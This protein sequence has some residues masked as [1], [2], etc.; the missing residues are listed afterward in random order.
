MNNNTSD[1]ILILGSRG[2][3][4]SRL[5]AHLQEKGCQV[6][7]LNENE[8][9]FE[10]DIVADYRSLEADDLKPYQVVIWLAGHSSV[11]AATEDPAGAFE[12]NVSG[13]LRLADSLS[14]EQ[15]LI[16]ASSASLYSRNPDLPPSTEI[17]E[18][19]IGEEHQN[20]YD[21]SKFAFDKLLTKRRKN[22][23]GL[24]FGTVCG[25][26]S[27]P[28]N[29]LLLNSMV[30]SAVQTGQVKVSNAQAMRSV[31]AMNDLIEMVYLLV[32]RRPAPGFYDLASYSM[33][34]GDFGKT[35]AAQLRAELIEVPGQG[36][37]SFSVSARKIYSALDYPSPTPINYLID[38]LKAFYS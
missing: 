25:T 38:E 10:N 8:G 26:S 22:F 19:V 14:E 28:R 21:L 3:I 15:T 17:T 33:S 6:Q 4:G 30:R 13:L 11:S 9:Q 1:K 34:I 5:Y 24:R 36:T 16:Y 18:E 27:R 12:N 29:E 23:Y 35:V 37:Y 2:Y 7:G 31:L 32:Q 20:A